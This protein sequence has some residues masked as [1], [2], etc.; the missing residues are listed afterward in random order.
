MHKNPGKGGSTADADS[1]TLS[2]EYAYGSVTIAYSDHDSDS[3]TAASDQKATSY[4]VTYTV[5][6]DISVSY[7]TEE[8][9]SN[10]AA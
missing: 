5:T 6:D 4:K 9:D 10:G 3:N 2:A 8:I 1:T 7:G